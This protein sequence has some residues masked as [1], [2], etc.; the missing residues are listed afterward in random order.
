MNR[1]SVKPTKKSPQRSARGSRATG[2]HASRV[3][4]VQVQSV[5][6]WLERKGT[7]RTRDGMARYA[8]PCDKAF[9][10][11][12]GMLRQYAKRLGRN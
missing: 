4:Y 1:T 2:S 5:V 12:V 3:Q 10:I 8:I 11:P 7:K 9:G 6:A